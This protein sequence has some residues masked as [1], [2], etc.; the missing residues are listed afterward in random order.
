MKMDGE[1][2]SDRN[3]DRYW[4]RERMKE[5]EK[6]EGEKKPMNIHYKWIKHAFKRLIETDAVDV[7]FVIIF[8]D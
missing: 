4:F 6:E 3:I 1:R 5:I 7:V 8:Q 2:Y